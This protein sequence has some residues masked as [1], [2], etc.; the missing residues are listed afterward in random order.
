MPHCRI[1]IR[2]NRSILQLT[3]VMILQLVVDS[4]SFHIDPPSLRTVDGPSTVCTSTI[5]LLIPKTTQTKYELSTDHVGILFPLR[6]SCRL[7]GRT[8]LKLWP[9]ALTIDI[10]VNNKYTL[11]SLL[12]HSRRTPHGVITIYNS[13]NK[14]WTKPK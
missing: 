10:L 6:S 4:P 11:W 1:F 8:I 7:G 14:T 13:I 3:T 9:I 2:E 5:R 12:D